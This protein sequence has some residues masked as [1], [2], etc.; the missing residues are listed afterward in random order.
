MIKHKKTQMEFNELRKKILEE[1]NNKDNITKNKNINNNSCLIEGNYNTFYN[2]SKSKNQNEMN[3]YKT[4]EQ[5]YIFY[6]MNKENFYN[7][8]N[9]KNNKKAN[10]NNIIE[11][12]K[13]KLLKYLSNDNNNKNNTKNKIEKNLINDYLS[14]SKNFGINKNQTN[15]IISIL[16]KYETKKI[17]IYNKSIHSLRIS[18]FNFSFIKNGLNNEENRKLIKIYEKKIQQL[19]QKLME[20]NEKIASLNN[21]INNNKVEIIKLK[22][23]LN[24]KNKKNCTEIINRNSDSLIIKLPQNF[25]SQKIF[26][27]SNLT[28]DI[29][30]KDNSEYA[31]NR[32]NNQNNSSLNDGKI[33]KKK[34]YTKIY[35]KANI[36]K[37]TFS[38]P[39]LRIKGTIDKINNIL[40][41]LKSREKYHDLLKNQIF[42]D[43]V[44]I[45]NTQTL[46]TIYPLSTSQKLLSFDL[47]TKNFL[48]KSI[49]TNT[50]DEFAKNFMES[51]NSEESEDN[52]NY[53]YINNNIYIITG[54]NSDIFYKYNTINNTM[55]K[56]C[57]L[58]NNHANGVLISYNDNI[59]CISGKFNKKVE[60][61][62]EE[63]KQWE[64]INELNIERSYFSACIIHN[65]YIF[66]LFGYNSPSNKYLDSIEF[67][68]MSN[69]NY[70]L[71]SWKY[72]KYKNNDLINMNICGFVCMNYLNEKIIIFG[73]IN[74]I[75][76][77]P[78]DKIYQIILDKNFLE[79]NDENNFVEEYKEIENDIY[80][81]KCY[82]FQ[83]GLGFFE[84]N[85]INN[86]NENKK[87]F[88]AGF[89]NNFNVHVIKINE[90]LSHDIHYFH[91]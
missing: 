18:N 32:L 49:N 27:E 77:K 88:Y 45:N 1:N 38:Q 67:C 58:K 82:Y 87:Y 36:N 46:Y 89:D 28:E 25:Q 12:N 3:N 73:G 66:C 48:F 23:Q 22:E 26:D 81:N 83:T 2:L 37:R 47:N 79:E 51:F 16:N 65:K 59:F 74:G 11:N 75:E 19:D 60:L 56:I 15:D 9:I 13:E 69:L 76:K 5:N 90:A 63:K 54:K 53:L 61:F 29:I 55:E 57:T 7:N 6:L 43:K 62:S 70:G 10:T 14:E 85:E 50:S 86:E 72:L 84:D 42:N 34:I 80:K 44:I 31:T 21:T 24:Q 8:K 4:N 68:D 33:Y 52:S 71:C 91:K 40:N 41:K 17:K 20:A 39:N 35:K 78:V 64:E 30:N